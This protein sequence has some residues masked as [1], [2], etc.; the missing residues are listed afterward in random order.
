MESGCQRWLIVR[1][2]APADF[3]TIE[4]VVA[5]FWPAPPWDSS[6]GGLRSYHQSSGDGGK[7]SQGGE[8]CIHGDHW[9]GGNGYALPHDPQ[10]LGA[11]LRIKR[12]TLTIDST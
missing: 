10:I 9:T 6:D 5:D 2:I 12:T 11:G 1:Y 3:A 8:S 7:T 4:D